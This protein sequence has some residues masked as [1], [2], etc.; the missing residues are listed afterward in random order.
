[1]SCGC[2]T[3]E[4]TW[5]SFANLSSHACVRVHAMCLFVHGFVNAHC[6]ISPCC[7]AGVA[8]S[9]SDSFTTHIAH[10]IFI[11]SHKEPL[12]YRQERGSYWS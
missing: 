12:S 3:H 10:V 5:I 6:K 9:S 1:M 4:G 2:G 7:T 8:A 11:E